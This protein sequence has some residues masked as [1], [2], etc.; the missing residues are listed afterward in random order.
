M[1]HTD[2]FQL[3]NMNLLTTPAPKFSDD[4]ETFL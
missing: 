2:V 4:A 1:D 3:F